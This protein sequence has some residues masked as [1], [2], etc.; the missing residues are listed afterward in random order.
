MMRLIALT[1]ELPDDPDEVV[2]PLV[3]VVLWALRH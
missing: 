3:D 2:L 1:G